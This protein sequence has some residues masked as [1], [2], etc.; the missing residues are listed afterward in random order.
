MHLRGW[1]AAPCWCRDAPHRQVN[2][3]AVFIAAFGASRHAGPAPKK[4]VRPAVIAHSIFLSS[5][6]LKFYTGD[7]AG[8]RADLEAAKGVMT[9]LDA[10]SITEKPECRYRE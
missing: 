8:A 6:I 5:G 1:Y 7:L 10:V 2:D 9:A 4:S 3:L